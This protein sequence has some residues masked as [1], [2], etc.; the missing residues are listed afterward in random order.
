MT[1]VTLSRDMDSNPSST[2][3]AEPPLKSLDEA[4]AAVAGL[5]A[6]AIAKAADDLRAHLGS[7]QDTT[8]VAYQNGVTMLRAADEFVLGARATIKTLVRPRI[9]RPEHRIKVVGK[10]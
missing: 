4:R 10:A 7:A 9:L 8:T 3:P 6:Q 1:A 2:P 5:A